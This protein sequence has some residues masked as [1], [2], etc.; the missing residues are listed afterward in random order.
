MCVRE[1]AECVSAL[2]R[3][4][5]DASGTMSFVTGRGLLPISVTRCLSACVSGAYQACVRCVSDV[6]QLRVRCVSD[7]SDV[8]Q[9]C[10]GC[11][12]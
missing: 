7:V 6:C 10:I 2:E 11:V 5:P 12:G 8:C 1:S 9:L 4:R 3:E